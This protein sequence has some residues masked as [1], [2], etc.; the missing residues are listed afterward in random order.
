MISIKNIVL[1]IFYYRTRNIYFGLYI[2]SRETKSNVK[3]YTCDLRGNTSVNFSENRFFKKKKKKNL[4]EKKK[5]CLISRFSWGVSGVSH[6]QLKTLNAFYQLPNYQLPIFINLV[7]YNHS[8]D[9]CHTCL[10]FYYA[11]GNIR[12]TKYGNNSHTIDF[13]TIL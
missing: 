7:F 10:C 4:H 3:R 6:T 5:F 9:F 13:H 12:H 8:G 1:Q 2:H 11:C